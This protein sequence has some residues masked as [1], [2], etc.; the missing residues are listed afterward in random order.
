MHAWLDSPCVS[1]PCTCIAYPVDGYGRLHETMPHSH[2]P[3]RCG[4]LTR[5]NARPYRRTHGHVSTPHPLIAPAGRLSPCDAGRRPPTPWK[6]SYL[7]ETA[8]ALGG[9]RRGLPVCQVPLSL[10]DPK[11]QKT[12]WFT[13]AYVP[14]IFV[15]PDILRPHKN[16]DSFSWPD[17]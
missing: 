16:R 4:Y 7:P 15:A 8:L 10:Q 14:P 6:H 2:M 11:N 17:R 5:C 1:V 12:L 3:A 13:W 9:A